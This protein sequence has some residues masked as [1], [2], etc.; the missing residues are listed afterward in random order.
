MRQN[1]VRRAQRKIRAQTR[2]FDGIQVVEEGNGV[3]FCVKSGRQQAAVAAIWVSALF[4]KGAGGRCL[5][6]VYLLDAR[7][8][9]EDV[10][11]CFCVVADA[12]DAGDKVAGVALEED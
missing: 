2:S 4:V 5:G 7:V 9:A 12:L 8:G 1:H 3:L 6:V 10:A 11:D